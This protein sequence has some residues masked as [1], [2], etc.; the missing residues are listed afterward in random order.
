MFVIVAVVVVGVIFLCG[1]L[2]GVSIAQNQAADR[3]R[4]NQRDRHIS[5]VRTGSVLS[6]S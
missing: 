6:P 1:A 2:M 3:A 5:A 4:R